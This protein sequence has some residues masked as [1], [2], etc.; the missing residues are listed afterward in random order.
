ME[1]NQETPK[2]LGWT[3]YIWLII[4][5]ISFAVG[6]IGIV[7][8]LL[9]TVPFYMLTVFAL[10]RGSE[11]FHKKFI[12]SSLYQKTVGAYEKDK[13]MTMRSKLT[14][15]SSVTLLMGIGA[16][17]SRHIPIVLAI[18]AVVW[19][20]HVIGLFFF[21]KTKQGEGHET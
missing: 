2:Q 15:L 13:S 7:L 8:P 5:G 17:F 20:G 16:Y 4:A 18:L 21:V 6:T 3:R 12:E 9:P 11:R 10:T 14:I 19:I 1:Q